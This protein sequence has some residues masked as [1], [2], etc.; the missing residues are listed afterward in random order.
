MVT[1]DNS[2]SCLWWALRGIFSISCLTAILDLVVAPSNKEFYFLSALGFIWEF[3]LFHVWWPFWIQ[4][5]P[6]ATRILFPV[7]SGGYL[8]DPL[9]FYLFQLLPMATINLLYILCVIS[10]VTFYY[11]LF[12][13]TC[14]GRSHIQLSNKK[15]IIWYG[16]MV[17]S[18]LYFR[19]ILLLFFLNIWYCVRFGLVES[20]WLR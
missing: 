10:L 19:I 3:S 9:I 20:I 1:I 13:F 6:L 2:T 4:L 11:F 12:L 8:W 18:H 7:W 15:L 17:I 16:S 5:L 14:D